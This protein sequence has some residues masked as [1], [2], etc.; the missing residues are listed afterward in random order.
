[1]DASAAT[2]KLLEVYGHHAFSPALIL[3]PSSV[4]LNHFLGPLREWNLRSVNRVFFNLFVFGR[5]RGTVFL[6][7]LG[8]SL[9]DQ[10]SF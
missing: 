7:Q 5:G 2:A 4:K 3:K 9:T 1:M 10:W 8:K 6:G